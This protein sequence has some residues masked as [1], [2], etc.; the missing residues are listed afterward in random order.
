MDATGDGLLT[1]Y[2]KSRYEELFTYKSEYLSFCKLRPLI[3]QAKG[4]T[5]VAVGIGN[6][7][8]I[9]DEVLLEIAGKNGHVI[10]VE[11]YKA[12]AKRINEIVS[13]ACGMYCLMS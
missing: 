1:K 2:C 8:D 4:V 6:K 13:S 12:L 5:M 10:N 3:A 9:R 7:F 11:S